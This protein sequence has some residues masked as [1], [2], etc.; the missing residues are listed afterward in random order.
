MTT[1]APLR[2]PDFDDRGGPTYRRAL[3]DVV[4]G[5]VDRSDA[6]SQNIENVIALLAEKTVEVKEIQSTVDRLMV[7]ADEQ[8]QFN[9]R[10][11][12]TVDEQ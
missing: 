1:F 8:V 3:H 12:E 9:Q 7:Q 4:E 2:V 6:R 11:K 10:L 5:L